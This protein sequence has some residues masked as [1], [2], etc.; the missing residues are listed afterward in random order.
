MRV[1]RGIHSVAVAIALTLTMTAPA[2]A[3]GP[4]VNETSG[5]ACSA[6]I[7]PANHGPGTGGC[8]VFAANSGKIEIGTA[9]GMT[10]CDTSFEGKLNANGEGYAYNQ[11]ISG[12]SPISSTPCT[13]PEGGTTRTNWPIEMT[14]E[15]SMETIFCATTFGI[16]VNCHLP[17]ITVTLSG[18]S[19]A[20]TYTTGQSHQFCENSA[21]NSI[22]GTWNGIINAA[23]PALESE[24]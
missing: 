7:P 16:T 4:I 18:A 21:T 11:V 6:I 15:T 2:V 13:S 8:P 5:V 22:Q 1:Q 10:L 9:L 19:H 17:G 20:A 23:H 14:S 12:C 3:I 24:G